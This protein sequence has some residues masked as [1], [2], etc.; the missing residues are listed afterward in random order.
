MCDCGSLW[1]QVETH[2]IWT[3]ALKFHATGEM[4]AYN[5]RTSDLGSSHGRTLMFGTKVGLK[6]TWFQF[7][8]W[9]EIKTSTNLSNRKSGANLGLFSSLLE[10]SACFRTAYQSRFNLGRLQ[11]AASRLATNYTAKEGET[12]ASRHKSCRNTRQNNKNWEPDAL[13]CLIWCIK[14]QAVCV[15]LTVH[16][17]FTDLNQWLSL[18]ANRAGLQRS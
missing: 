10:R 16:H 12:T 17:L 4:T 7:P 18:T 13:L 8:L 2:R 5:H 14:Q 3:A 15:K 1:I 6:S 11:D 9:G